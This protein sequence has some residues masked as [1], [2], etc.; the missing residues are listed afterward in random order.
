MATDFQSLILP[1]D[2][3]KFFFVYCWSTYHVCLVMAD[4]LIAS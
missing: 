2:Q 1:D 4:L 3:T